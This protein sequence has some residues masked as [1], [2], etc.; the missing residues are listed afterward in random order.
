M[1]ADTLYILVKSFDVYCRACL[2]LL[3]RQGVEQELRQMP[4]LHEWEVPE[5]GP[6]NLSQLLRWDGRGESLDEG[7]HEDIWKSLQAYTWPEEDLKRREFVKRQDPELLDFTDVSEQTRLVLWLSI[8]RYRRVS[9]EWEGHQNWLPNEIMGFVVS[10]LRCNEPHLLDVCVG[11][12]RCAADIR[13]HQD[14]NDIAATFFRCGAMFLLIDQANR[15]AKEL[16]PEVEMR[17]HFS[18]RREQDPE[19]WLIELMFHRTPGDEQAWFQAA[20]T[21]LGRHGDVVE[22][23]RAVR[24]LLNRHKR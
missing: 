14:P 5:G 20:A 4:V 24:D 19:G 7:E 18:S 3:E 12:L 2:D 22:N 23:L 8:I 9:F 17:E 13:W 10:A 6:E 16:P 21:S 1:S 15:L 11:L